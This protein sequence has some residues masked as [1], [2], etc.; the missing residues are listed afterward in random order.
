V[1][2]CLRGCLVLFLAFATF[3]AKA[4]HIVGG[5]LY[6]TYLG[7]NQ[8]EIRLTVYRDCFY[9]NPPFDS[10]A[11]I[12][13]WNANN[14]FVYAV[15]L[16]P[17]DSATIP[18]IINSPCFVPPTNVCYRVC[19]YYGTITLPPIAGGYQLAYQ[20]CCRNQTIINIVTPLDV[21]AAFYAYIPGTA[22]TNVNSNPVFTQLPPP[23]IC[24]GPRAWR[25]SC[26]IR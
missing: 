1:H 7:N 16:F 4:T 22:I 20:R 15:D 3:C 21:G 23:F 25:T 13:V 10:P 24:S 11:L 12:G 19:N 9:G 26:A 8:Y 5:E 18:P 6:Y 17:N 2:I 14:S